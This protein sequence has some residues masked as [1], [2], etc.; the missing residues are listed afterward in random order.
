MRNEAVKEKRFLLF[1]AVS[2]AVFSVLSFQSIVREPKSKAATTGRGPAS[3]AIGFEFLI[4]SEKPQAQ[5]AKTAFLDLNCASPQEATM[6][7][8]H[9]RIRA[10]N[11]GFDQQKGITVIN[12]TNGFEAAVVVNKDKSF[13][14]D[15]IDLKVG[16]NRFEVQGVDDTGMKVTHSFN[17]QNR[18]ASSSVHQ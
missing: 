17:I 13:T 1:V 14:T 4:A 6:E 9:V 16:S 11:C 8:T 5:F 10:F 15:F 18:Q 3:E 12:Q 7:V 2:V